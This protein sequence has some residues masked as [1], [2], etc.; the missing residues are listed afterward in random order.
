MRDVIVDE[1][2]IFG[3]LGDGDARFEAAECDVAAVVTVPAEAFGG[4]DDE[5]GDDLV[6]GKLDGE[7][8]G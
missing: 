2:E 8:G 5:R 6:V 1:V 3:G 4:V 7:W